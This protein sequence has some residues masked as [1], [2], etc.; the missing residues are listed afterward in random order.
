M[1]I[2]QPLAVVLA[3]LAA[4]A[5]IVAGADALERR[6]ERGINLRLAWTEAA[7]EDAVPLTDLGADLDLIRRMGLGHIRI[8]LSLA[9]IADETGRYPRLAQLRKLRR[10]VAAA[11]RRELA[12]VLT[13]HPSS[14]R[15]TELTRAGGEEANDVAALWEALAARLA[16]FGP[17][18]LV[19]EPLNE[20]EIEDR[21]R[22]QALQ[23]RLV[24]AIRAAA[25][26]HAVMAAG[27]RF[28]SLPELTALEPLERPRVLYSFHFYEPYNFTHQG[29]DWGWPMWEHFHSFPYPASPE[30]I[31][32]VLP[33]LPEKAREHAK[34]Y[35]QEKWNKA[36]LGERLDAAVAW[37]RKHGGLP[38]QC[39]E[40]GAYKPGIRERDRVAWLRDVREL[41]E[42][43][44][45]G[46]T[47]WDYAN[48]FGLVSGAQGERKID[49]AAVNA[50][51]LHKPGD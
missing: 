4:L 17:D 3:C 18:A 46:W 44:G 31:K 1:R 39:S 6:M 26:A 15:K 30:G 22:W 38:V 9:D 28:S 51:G 25:P 50:L 12:T 27:H 7:P 36:K 10:V 40:F 8:R 11:S 13:L 48:D 20:P 35:G 14:E 41:L 49:R 45:I 42:A 47:L 32:A 23:Q 5:P 21:E 33:E 16:D 34:H 43:R 24:D 19:F 37:S 2:A 29:A